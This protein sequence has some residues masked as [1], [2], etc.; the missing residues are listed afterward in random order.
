MDVI[1]L[2][3]WIFLFISFILLTIEMIFW[4]KFVVKIGITIYTKEYNS[5]MDYFVNNIGK[6]FEKKDVNIM[7]ID[8]DYCI[9]NYVPTT[10]IIDIHYPLFGYIKSIDNKY[11]IKFKI[12]FSLLLIIVLFTIIL[13]IKANI[14]NIGNLLFLLGIIIIITAIP[15]IMNILK[16]N[17]MKYDIEEYLFY[18]K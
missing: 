15:V 6:T 7:I 12:P 18:G 11:Y 10:F 9:F 16:L 8:K 14:I 2:I 3:N 13:F 5:K 17:A 4:E 1:E